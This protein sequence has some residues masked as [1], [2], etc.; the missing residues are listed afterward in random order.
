M[1]AF[2]SSPACAAAP[3]LV[4]KISR[5][6]ND[7]GGSVLVST[8]KGATAAVGQACRRKHETLRS[9]IGR[10]IGAKP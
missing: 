7:A 10:V 1:N 3:M 2:V 8:G 5:A 4:L 9:G 6:L